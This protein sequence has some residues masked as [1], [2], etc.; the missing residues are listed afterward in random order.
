QPPYTA[1]GYSCAGI[2]DDG[3]RLCLTLTPPAKDISFARIWDTT[4][5]RMIKELRLPGRDRLVRLAPDGKSLLVATST[6][7]DRPELWNLED[8][9]KEHGKKVAHVSGSFHEAVFS[10]DGRLIAVIHNDKPRVECWDTST[11]EVLL[12]FAREEGLEGR[13]LSAA[14]SPDSAVLAVGRPGGID[15]LQARTGKGIR[16]LKTGFLPVHVAFSHDARTLAI[17]SEKAVRFI[18]VASGTLQDPDGHIDVVTALAF[19][20]DGAR[21]ASLAHHGSVLLWDVKSRR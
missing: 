2:S 7:V 12:N 18:D 10:P 14:F 4:S 8:G 21:L 19:S 3:T 15:L 9:Q 11:G 13:A 6:S 20:S 1:L 17:A 5:G 16:T